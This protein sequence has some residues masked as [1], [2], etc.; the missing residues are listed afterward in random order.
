MP[1]Q[2]FMGDNA[3]KQAVAL[4]EVQSS[5]SSLQDVVAE[6]KDLRA[7]ATRVEKDIDLW[8]IRAHKL[9]RLCYWAIG[10]P[11]VAALIDVGGHL[12]GWLH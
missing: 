10:V 4:E 8:D 7:L 9:R 6:A 3:E 2:I 1:F 11:P 5:L 12:L